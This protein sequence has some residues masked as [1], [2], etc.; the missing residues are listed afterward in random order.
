VGRFS[1][2][3]G[4]YSPT[5]ACNG[6]LLLASGVEDWPVYV[7]NPVTGE[8]LKIPAPPKIQHIHWRMY[9]IGCTLST[10]CE[11]KLFRLSFSGQRFQEAARVNHL[12]VYTLGAGDNAGWRRHPYL[13]SCRAVYGLHSP[14][15]VL[16]DGKLYVVM[17]RQ[18]NYQARDSILVIDVASEAHS[19]FALPESSTR[20]DR[21]TTVHAFQLRGRLC[22]AVHVVGRPQVCFWVMSSLR[23]RRLIDGENDGWMPRWERRYTFYVEAKDRYG[24]QQPCGAWLDTRDGMLCYR[25]GELLY[26]YDTTKNKKHD[27]DEGW[28]DSLLE[29]DYQ[30]QLPPTPFP[31]LNELRWKVYGGYRPSLLSPHL[32]FASTSFLQQHRREREDCEQALLH[33]ARRSCKP[34]HD[35]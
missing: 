16:L 3:A 6:L 24:Y 9:A 21:V 31:T 13:F 5:N 12:D 23:G 29:W 2:L 28:V 27:Q 15:P 22:V 8:K 18:E 25:L 10:K 1:D 30:T 33:A 35:S 19:T 4:G 14:P 32:A 7:C 17:E 26:K 34:T 20:D 11:Y